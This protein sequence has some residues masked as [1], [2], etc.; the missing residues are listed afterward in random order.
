M[1][2]S[3]GEQ[4]AIHVSDGNIKKQGFSLSKGQQQQQ[5][6]PLDRFSLSIMSMYEAPRIF[7]LKDRPGEVVG[8][9]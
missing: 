2:A 6:P 9:G 5:R 3:E 7:K 8:V 1:L 4:K